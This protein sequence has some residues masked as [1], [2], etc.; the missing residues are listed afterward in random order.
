LKADV[1]PKVN[2][3]LRGTEARYKA[4]D[5]SLSELMVIRREAET[6]QMKYLEALRSVMEA[7]AGL[8]FG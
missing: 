3:I 5:I 1:L 7:W 8:K 4:G 2:A 6:S